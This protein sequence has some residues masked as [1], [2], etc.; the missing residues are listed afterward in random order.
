MASE[1]KV[2]VP[3]TAH[4]AVL[5]TMRFQYMVVVRPR[6]CLAGQVLL[7]N[8]IRLL[9]AGNLRRGVQ[10]ACP[11]AQE[12]A[13]SRLPSLQFHLSAFVNTH[14]IQKLCETEGRYLHLTQ[15]ASICIRRKMN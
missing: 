5:F 1:L 9:Q 2:L 4:V 15:S 11:R 10:M 13:E 6:S 7:L 3:C 8:L 14:L 12:V